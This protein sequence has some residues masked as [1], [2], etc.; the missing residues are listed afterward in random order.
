VLTD[1]AAGS[2]SGHQA[3]TADGRPAMV[4]RRAC[5]RDRGI[6]GEASDQ[7]RRPGKTRR[8]AAIASSSVRPP[9]S[10]SESLGNAWPTSSDSFPT[11]GARTFSSRGVMKRGIARELLLLELRKGS[12]GHVPDPS[13]PCGRRP[14]RMQSAHRCAKALR[15]GRQKCVRWNHL[16]Q[17]RHCR[18]SA[19]VPNIGIASGFG[20]RR[21]IVN[22]LLLGR[23]EI[24]SPHS[25]GVSTRKEPSLGVSLTRFTERSVID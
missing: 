17:A 25:P 22:L 19:G 23:D 15:L 16:P 5:W 21:R 6:A 11:E 3:R 2:S 1:V 9:R 7:H 8:V 20:L 13:L 14:L 18:P 12:A 10:F 24:D 4:N